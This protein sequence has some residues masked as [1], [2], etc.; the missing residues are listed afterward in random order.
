ME[1][2]LLFKESPV[3]ALGLPTITTLSVQC[4]DHKVPFEPDLRSWAPGS[5]V[6]TQDVLS[7]AMRCHPPVAEN[8]PG[9]P[10]L[11]TIQLR[12]SPFCSLMAAQI[13]AA[14][15]PSWVSPIRVAVSNGYAE[16]DDEYFCAGPRQSNSCNRGWRC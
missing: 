11:T 3:K 8:S 6:D 4:R 13:P 9:I 15:S 5:D 10:A 16:G 12:E 1:L 2:D 7:H 14:W